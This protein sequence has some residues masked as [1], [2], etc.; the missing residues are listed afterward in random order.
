MRRVRTCPG[1][2]SGGTSAA[3]AYN[4]ISVTG[5]SDDLVVEDCYLYAE[6]RL[7]GDQRPGQRDGRPD[8]QRACRLMG[9][10]GV[11]T[12]H[13]INMSGSG[14]CRIHQCEIQNHAYGVYATGQV[15]G[16]MISDSFIDSSRTTSLYVR[17]S[18]SSN[19]LIAN[20]EAETSGTNSMNVQAPTLSWFGG[21]GNGVLLI[22]GSTACAVAERAAALFRHVQPASGAG[23]S[24]TGVFSCPVSAVRPA[25]PA[26]GVTWG[27]S[28]GIEPIGYWK[29]DEG[30]GTTAAD[31]SGFGRDA[32]LQN[33]A[34]WAAGAHGPRRELVA[35]R[36][37]LRISVRRGPQRLASAKPGHGFLHGMPPG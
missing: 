7:V 34:G 29:F 20:L 22:G 32:T 28:P 10:D 5:I 30:S 25:R 15:V 16:L 36:S 11:N 14:A 18:G 17:G 6:K 24:T 37:R 9:N 13:G 1:S 2:Y 31:S 19:V 27:C 3:T 23:G 12:G 26:A 8:Y 4:G 33:G 21:Y 35:G